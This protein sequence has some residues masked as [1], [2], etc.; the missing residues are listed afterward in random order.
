MFRQYI[1]ALLCSIAFGYCSQTAVAQSKDTSFTLLWYKGQKMNDSAVLMPS[2]QKVTFKPSNGKVQVLTPAK[3][4][5][6]N[7]L[8]R[9]LKKSE[10]RKAQ[11]N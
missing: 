6:L 3:Q 1:P 5:V 10:E 9:E 8:S 4:D 11:L 2:G 7:S